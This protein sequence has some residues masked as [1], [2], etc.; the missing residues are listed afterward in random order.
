MHKPKQNMKKIISMLLIVILLLCNQEAKAVKVIINQD[1][2]VRKTFG[3]VEEESTYI[4]GNDGV[5][6][7]VERKVHC[8]Q[9]GFSE[10]R[11]S[12][13]GYVLEPE[14][15]LINQLIDYANLKFAEGVNSGT[16]NTSVT[17]GFPDGTIIVKNYQVSWVKISDTEY[18]IVINEI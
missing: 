7:L 3:V 1:N 8:S 6:R 15:E 11:P 2:Y 9:P 12:A 4:L 13:G 17:I 10:C 14:M 16:H 5:M 18:K